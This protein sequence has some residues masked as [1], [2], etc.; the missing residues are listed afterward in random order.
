GWHNQG[1]KLAGDRRSTA[2]QVGSGSYQLD[3]VG[4]VL[5]LPAHDADQHPLIVKCAFGLDQLM[6]PCV[7]LGGR[8]AALPIKKR[9]V[10]EFSERNVDDLDAG[11]AEPRQRVCISAGNSW[12]HVIEHYGLRC[13]KPQ[14]I[15]P[16]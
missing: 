7:S 6:V 2:D 12:L 9:D 3:I 10:A 8:K 16:R 13:R 15:K 1:I 5:V 14:S 11:L 4:G